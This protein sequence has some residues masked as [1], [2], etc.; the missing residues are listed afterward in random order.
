MPTTLLLVP[1]DFRP[2]AIPEI[3]MEII[4][5]YKNRN[6]LWKIGR[7]YKNFGRFSVKVGTVDFPIKHTNMGFC[8]SLQF[9]YVYDS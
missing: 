4:I 3:V 9:I 6:F 2:V 7:N 5:K 8:V 1:L